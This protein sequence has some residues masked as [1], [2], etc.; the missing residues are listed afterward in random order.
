LKKATLFII[1]F[2]FSVLVFS[3]GQ[4]LDTT[5]VLNEVKVRAYLSDQ[6]LISTPSSAVIINQNQLSKNNI[7]QSL[8]PVL[9][10]IAG[11]KME[12]RSPGSYRISIRGSLLR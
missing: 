1:L 3:Q 11:V 8:L 9:N 4:N 6:S 12:E 2:F 5:K 10:G 7:T